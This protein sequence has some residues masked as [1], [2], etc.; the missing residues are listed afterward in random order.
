MYRC[1][2]CRNLIGPNIPS[3]KVVA[4]TRPVE[5]PFRRDANRFVKER[6]EEKR[7]DPGGSGFE[8]ERE[9]VACAGCAGKKS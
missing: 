2:L 9:V 1:E 6:K 4:Q 3:H 5:Y 7:D 8:I